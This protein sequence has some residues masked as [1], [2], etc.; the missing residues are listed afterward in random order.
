MHM[1]ARICEKPIVC[2]ILE[3]IYFSITQSLEEAALK[4]T[5]FADILYLSLQESLLSN[6]MPESQ[7]LLWK[8]V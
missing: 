1:Y 4:W 8:K 2:G 6:L 3:A 5:N 7:F